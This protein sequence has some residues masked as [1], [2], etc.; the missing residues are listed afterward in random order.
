[1]S[2]LGEYR[3]L[4]PEALAEHRADPGRAYE[5]IVELGDELDLDRSWA[6]L[7]ALLELAEFPVNPVTGGS[8]F[9]DEQS[10]WDA[11]AL[12]AGQV[13]TAAAHLRR[14][15]FEVLGRHLRPLLDGEDWRVLPPQPL[16]DLSWEELPRCRA[17]E[18]TELAIRQTLAAAYD[19]LV[20]YFGEAAERGQCTVF[21]AA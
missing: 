10:T 17:D 16:I 12:D 18:A 5:R 14:T 2:V 3:R 7:A 6:R 4:T 9:P 11:R 1:M 15:P 13:A 8:P 20:R 19:S 21:W